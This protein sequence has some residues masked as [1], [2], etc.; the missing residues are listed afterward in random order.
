[1][2]NTTVVHSRQFLPILKFFGEI[3][4][5]KQQEIEII[6]RNQNY[7]EFQMHLM[8]NTI[9]SFNGTSPA[10]VVQKYNLLQGESHLFI[11][12]TVLALIGSNTMDEVIESLSG[13]PEFRD[14]ISRNSFNKLITTDCWWLFQDEEDNDLDISDELFDEIIEYL[15]DH[16]TS[17]MEICYE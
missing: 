14:D 11:E 1:M 17:L 12:K 15:F 9:K 3:K 13:N 7:C 16:I 5:N 2:N 8:N 6:Q 10:H 4:M